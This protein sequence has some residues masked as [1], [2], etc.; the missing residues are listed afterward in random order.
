M[1]R[2]DY[3]KKNEGKGALWGVDMSEPHLVTSRLA[4]SHLAWAMTRANGS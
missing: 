4:R 1:P 2:Y 3:M